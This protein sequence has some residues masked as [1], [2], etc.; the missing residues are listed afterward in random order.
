MKKVILNSIFAICIVVSFSSCEP[1]PKTIDC[2]SGTWENDNSKILTFESDQKGQLNYADTIY[3]FT[4][5]TEKGKIT[6]NYN[7]KTAKA[8]NEVS[9]INKSE[10]LSYR[11]NCPSLI[12]DN[13]EWRRIGDCNGKEPSNGGN[14]GNSGGSFIDRLIVYDSYKV[15]NLGGPGMPTVPPGEGIIMVYFEEFCF[16][17]GETV[18]VYVSDNQDN[19]RLNDISQAAGKNPNFGNKNGVYSNFPAGTYL[20]SLGYGGEVYPM[21]NVTIQSNRY[22]MVPF[23]YRCE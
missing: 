22:I 12:I 23:T 17:A 5:K 7:K 13:K 3:D 1:E 14:N 9:E 11:C 21:G 18:S 19:W 2:L 6:L 8:N 4:Y 20:I 15:G 16:N 10:T